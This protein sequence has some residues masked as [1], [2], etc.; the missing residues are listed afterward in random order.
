MCVFLCVHVLVLALDKRL[1]CF[2]PTT[3]LHQAT[4]LLPQIPKEVRVVADRYMK[5]KGK[6]SSEVFLVVLVY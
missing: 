5:K 2:S 1:G 3:T 6:A 4:F